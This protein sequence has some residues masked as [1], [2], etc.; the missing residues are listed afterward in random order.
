MRRRRDIRHLFQQF[1]VLRVAAEFVVAD[2]RSIGRSTE[3]AVRLIVH[4]LENLALVEF[5][6]LLKIFQELRLGDVENLD[7]QHGRGLGLEDEVMQPAPGRLQ[8]L[9]FGRVQN[10]VELA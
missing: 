8:V 5:R 10:F 9:N 6:R 2:Q 4:L 3:D 1:D 7:L